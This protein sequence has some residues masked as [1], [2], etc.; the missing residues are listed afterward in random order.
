MEDLHSKNIVFR[1]PKP[2]NVGF[3][4]IGGVKL[5]DFGLTIGLPEGD[6][7]NPV[8][9]LYIRCGTPQ[10]MAP[11]VGLSLGYRKKFDV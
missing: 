6:K 4:Q 1:D 9:F 5:F 2:D 3:G 10:Y 11:E 8:R 7:S